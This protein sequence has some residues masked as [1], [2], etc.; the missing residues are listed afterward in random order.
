MNY[1]EQ[2]S[3][4]DKRI[5]LC[6]SHR[7]NIKK[8][9]E[10]FSAGKLGA[11]EYQALIENYNGKGTITDVFVKI[12]QYEEQCQDARRKLL[13][14]MKKKKRSNAQIAITFTMIFIVAM[15][16]VIFSD[17]GPGVTGAS[18]MEVEELVE[19]ISESEIK[20]ENNALLE[21]R[22]EWETIKF[23]IENNL[24]ENHKYYES[25]VREIK[26]SI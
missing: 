22:Q 19:N 15:V 18:V 7:Q 2:L 9:I 4:I 5:A 14:S 16:G 21:Y 26:S 6:E 13:N 23:E 10:D 3:E 1:K 20:V 25:L 11:D 12:N 24:E 17:V 8:V